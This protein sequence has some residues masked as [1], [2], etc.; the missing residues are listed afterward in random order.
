MCSSFLKSTS[1]AAMSA[2]GM[3]T[4]CTAAVGI[5]VTAMAAMPRLVTQQQAAAYLGVHVR[6]VRNKISEGILTGYRL[7]GLRAVRLD[8]DEIQ[9]KMQAMPTALKRRHGP[10]SAKGSDCP[11]GR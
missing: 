4:T 7:P 6:T 9:S 1:R 5:A 3:I 2:L 11:G 10:A 8:L